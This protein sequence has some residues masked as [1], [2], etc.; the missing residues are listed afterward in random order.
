MAKG[1]RTSGGNFGGPL[2]IVQAEGV[3]WIE[4]RNAQQIRRGRR[5]P[6]GMHD[7]RPAGFA[8]AFADEGAELEV[9]AVDGDGVLFLLR[10]DGR[11][12]D[13]AFSRTAV[14]AVVVRSRYPSVRAGDR[15]RVIERCWIANRADGRART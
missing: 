11:D 8:P 14:G 10:A 4:D 2:G 5:R 3:G 1:R 15:D 13:R 9:H 6:D 7:R 12:V